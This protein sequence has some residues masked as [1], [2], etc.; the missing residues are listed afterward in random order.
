MKAKEKPY[1]KMTKCGTL[2]I[3]HI[4]PHMSRHGIYRPHSQHIKYVNH[5]ISE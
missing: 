3:H 5:N 1:H 2:I 4:G